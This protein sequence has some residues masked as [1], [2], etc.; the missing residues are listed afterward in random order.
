[1]FLDPKACNSNVIL[2]RWAKPQLIELQVHALN[3]IANLATVA[4]D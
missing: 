4:H 2:T 3:I 1:M